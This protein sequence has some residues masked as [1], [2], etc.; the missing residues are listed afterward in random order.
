MPGE[1]APE[2]VVRGGRGKTGFYR[3]KQR[4]QRKRSGKRTGHN[5][6]APVNLK[7]PDPTASTG[8]PIPPVGR[9][10]SRALEKAPDALSLLGA[11]FTEG[12]K[13][14]KGL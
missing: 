2:A 3:S 7:K 10:S 8:P 5:S 1:V 13:A 9:A 14:N 4:K 12:N 6:S 11:R